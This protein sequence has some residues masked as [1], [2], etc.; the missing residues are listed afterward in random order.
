VHVGEDRR[1]GADFAGWLGWRF[2]SPRGG[3]EML[4]E[5]LVD[6][7]VGGKDLDCRLS[8]WSLRLGLAPDHGWRFLDLI[9]LLRLSRFSIP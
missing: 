1:N 9:I 7:L 6:A 4:D 5:K 2:C 8:D 3:V